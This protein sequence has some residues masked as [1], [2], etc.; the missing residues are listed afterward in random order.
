MT[1]ARVIAA[2]IIQLQ[3][4]MKRKA[5]SFERKL[6]CQ[7]I[8]EQKKYL[9]LYID[10]Q[11]FAARHLTFTAV[12]GRKKNRLTSKK[13]LCKQSDTQQGTSLNNEG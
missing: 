2:Y 6:L 1:H 13:L 12:E 11:S 4:R 5:S 8:Y 10:F 9:L 3:E 7:D